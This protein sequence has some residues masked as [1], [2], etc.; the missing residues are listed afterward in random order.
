M[1]SL[2]SVA[3]VAYEN[4]VQHAF[5][6]SGSDLHTTVRV[7]DAPQPKVYNFRK[8]GSLDMVPRGA[9]GSML[10][11]LSGDH[12]NVPCTASPFVLPVGTDE[13]EQAETGGEAP[14]EQSESALAIGYAMARQRDYSVIA[15]LEASTPTLTVTCAAGLTVAKLLEGLIPFDKYEMRAR[16]G[17][18]TGDGRLHMAISEVEHNNLLADAKTEDID[19]ST[20]K[21]LADGKMQDFAGYSF[22]LIG[23]GR[24][25]KG[26]VGS[27]PRRCYAWVKSAIGQAV[28][29]APRVKMGYELL[30]TSDVVVGQLFVGSVAIDELGIVQF[31]VTQA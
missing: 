13:F 16:S 21:S 11:L 26:L 28:T 7:K 1:A 17:V 27:A 5:Q 14:M 29:L 18:I 12:S 10:N 3:R 23:T 4:D 19:T 9:Y 15:A 24:G 25:T 8:F 31:D 22:I 2:S 30:Y 6:S 20:F